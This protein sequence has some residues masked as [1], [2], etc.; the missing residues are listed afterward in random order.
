M[1]KESTVHATYQKYDSM[2]VLT[3]LTGH[4]A[5]GYGGAFKNLGMG[6]GS[7]A[8]KLHMHSDL[9]P[10]INQEKC[11]GCSTCI[12]N[13]N[14]DAIEIINGKAKIDSEKCAGCPNQ[15]D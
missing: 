3:H 14:Y 15:S 2:I 9:R 12:E 6:L 7:R 4:I 13:C 1:Q 8:G 10:T 11:I 5:A